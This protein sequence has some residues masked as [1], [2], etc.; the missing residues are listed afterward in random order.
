MCRG[1]FSKIFDVRDSQSGERLAMKECVLDDSMRPKQ[2]F[3]AAMTR[4]CILHSR[5]HFH[6]NIV[7]VHDCD[8]SDS[9]LRL[10]MNR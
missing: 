8:I 9:C 5:V 3:Q 10:V 2:Y 1:A 6:P 4:E 7:R